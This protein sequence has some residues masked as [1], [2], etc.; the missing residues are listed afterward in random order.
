MVLYITILNILSAMKISD[1]GED[2]KMSYILRQCRM[3]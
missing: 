2:I 1:S 3:N